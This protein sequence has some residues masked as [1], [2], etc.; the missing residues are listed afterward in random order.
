[1]DGL[2]LDKTLNLP[3]R[4]FQ[5]FAEE[6]IPPPKVDPDGNYDSKD[7]DDAMPI[8]EADAASYPDSDSDSPQ[9]PPQAIDNISNRVKNESILR[10]MTLPPT[11]QP[12][13]NMNKPM[14]PAAAT[15]DNLTGRYLSKR[16]SAVDPASLE[17]KTFSPSQPLPASSSTVS[18][19]VSD[20]LKFH[21][22]RDEMMMMM[23][24]AR[25]QR[26]NTVAGSVGSSGKSA[27]DPLRHH[28]LQ[29][30]EGEGEEGDSDEVDS[31]D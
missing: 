23:S 1:M 31:Q 10:S 21:Q 4:Y 8:S 12:S 26:V 19:S 20:G 18:A 14:A 6:H 5:H 27:T 29:A 15:G 24:M 11:L 30:E 3:S 7:V 16:P 25:R 9:N 28:A 22:R 13:L 17:P 2:G